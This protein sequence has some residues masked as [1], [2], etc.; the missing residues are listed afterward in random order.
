MNNNNQQLFEKALK[1]F[2]NGSIII[3]DAGNRRTTLI[4][5]GKTELVEFLNAVEDVKNR[6]LVQAISDPR[7]RGDDIQSVPGSGI[8]SNKKGQNNG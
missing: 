6:V 4:N 5:E 1:N 8:K 3:W 2:E 7:L